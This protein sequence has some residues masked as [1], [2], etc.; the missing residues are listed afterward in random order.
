MLLDKIPTS[1]IDL[2]LEKRILPFAGAGISVD[3]GLPLGGQLAQELAA[4]LTDHLD[5]DTANKQALPELAQAY[6]TAFGRQHLTEYLIAR[7]AADG[8]MPNE[9]HRS[10]VSLFQQILTTNY[11]QMFEVALQHDGKIPLVAVRDSSLPYTAMPERTVIYKL[12][13]DFTAPE[14]LVITSRDYTRV[15]LSPGFQNELRHFLMTRSILFLGYG[16]RDIDFL[17]QLDFC[18][19]LVKDLPRSYAV[20]PGI[21]R[22]QLFIKQCD[23]DGID[24]FSFSAASFL[25]EL[26]GRIAQR[27]QEQKSK[28]AAESKRG[29]TG[30]E[31]RYKERLLD[32]F[33]YIDFRGIPVLGTY[34]RVEIEKLFV[35]ISAAPSSGEAVMMTDA[36]AASKVA[37]HGKGTHVFKDSVK[38][39]EIF[40]LLRKNRKLAIL[41]DPGSGKTTL[42][43]FICYELCKPE[44]DLKKIGLEKAYLP[45]FIPLREFAGYVQDNP[46]GSFED[47][48]QPLL[49]PYRLEP[50]VP[51][52]KSALR[53][54]RVIFLIDGLDEVAT[55][56]ER[57]KVGER[58]CKFSASYAHCRLILT[59]RRVGYVKLPFEGGLEHFVVRPLNKSEIHHFVDLWSKATN[60]SKTEQQG[61]LDA[62]EN[63]RV[64]ALAENPLLITILARVYKAYRNL[65]ERRAEL[66]KKCLEALLTTWDLTRELP[67]VF[68]D[69]RE[70]TR[71]MAP[72]A[73]WIHRDE[74]GKLVT[75]EAIVQKLSETPDLP[76]RHKPQQL[77]DQIETRSG[78]LRQ[79]GLN[80]YAFSHLTFQE[81]YVAR[82]VISRNRPFQE[83]KEFLVDDRWQEVII[84]TAGLLD[85]LGQGP[86]TSFMKSF[87]VK[88]NL[89]SPSAERLA[90]LNVLLGCIKDRAEPAKEIFN[91]IHDT[92]LYIVNNATGDQ[93][94]K[95]IAKLTSLKGFSKTALGL[96]LIEELK[97]LF[98]NESETIATNASV[99]A[100]R[101]MKDDHDQVALLLEF[102]KTVNPKFSVIGEAA[103]AIASSVDGS[104]EKQW[105]DMVM[106]QIHSVPRA[107]R[108]ELLA[109]GREILGPDLLKVLLK[110]WS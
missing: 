99:M 71:V 41:G 3:S 50:F 48:L 81:Y 54:G 62:I 87:V 32:E 55:Q 28:V 44:P 77:L 96:E 9:A 19:T 22:D 40:D 98:P 106:A 94:R 1:L 93:H 61:L 75:R 88:K 107:R 11:D 42:L 76:P 21:D 36:T 20:I 17:R 51:M 13:G 58:V 97:V 52:L 67:P 39:V 101:M 23:G 59:S 8:V 102:I 10:L 105:R 18:R 83:L 78:L 86:L 5:A 2:V 92:L 82:D 74:G 35:S 14:N 29:T 65:P 70:A 100:Y 37:E 109:R 85:E 110:I 24:V 43:R 46:K 68:E 57:I 60:T 4:K 95:I 72:L 64:L 26:Q 27:S 15:G 16:I 12:H 108:S 49:E 7:I 66:Y 25:K 31:L 53:E 33:R 90:K 69:A 6:E 89:L 30:E 63:P 45:L 73:M 91:F 56:E 103:W 80:Q 34:M 38:S 47:F 84:L 79:V 104:N